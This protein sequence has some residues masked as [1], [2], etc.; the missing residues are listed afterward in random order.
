MTF[1]EITNDV[2]IVRQRY[3]IFPIHIGGSA[4]YKEVKA[5]QDVVLPSDYDDAVAN[6]DGFFGDK[7]DIIYGFDYI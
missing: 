3:P 1:P 2:G 7:R 4:A 6:P 5:L